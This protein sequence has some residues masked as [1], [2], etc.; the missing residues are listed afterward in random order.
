MCWLSDET[1]ILINSN[2][3]LELFLKDNCRTPWGLKK[4]TGNGHKHPD[5]EQV[6]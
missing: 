2:F 4:L 1:D 3:V 6:R 5:F